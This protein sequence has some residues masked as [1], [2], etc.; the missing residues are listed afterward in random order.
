MRWV[1]LFVAS[2]FAAC[3]KVPASD[4]SGGLTVSHVTLAFPREEEGDLFF[5]VELPERVLRVGSV[6]WALT[7]AGQRFASGVVMTPDVVADASGRRRVRV[8]APL[9][10]R[11]LGWR[12][13]S[14]YLDVGVSGDV[15]P[16]A[17]DERLP[18]RDRRELLVTAAPL[19]DVPTP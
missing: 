7:V 18:F 9:V 12:D 16:L 14:A 8:D 17:S 2:L 19:F 5:E 15:V 4:V 13:G 3:P 1:W 6:R 10:Y 11:H